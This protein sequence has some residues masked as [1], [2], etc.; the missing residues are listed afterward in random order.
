MKILPDL[1]NLK[2]GHCLDVVA[3]LA[4]GLALEQRT[5]ALG[6]RLRGWLLDLAEGIGDLILKAGLAQNALADRVAQ[7][8]LDPLVQLGRGQCP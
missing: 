4:I 2:I 8:V 7:L 3:P 5:D 1:R 6:Q